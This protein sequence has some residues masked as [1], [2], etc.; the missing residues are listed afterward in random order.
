MVDPVLR[1]DAG[2]RLNESTIVVTGGAG[3][4]GS[5]VVA[6]LLAEGATVKVIDDLSTGRLENLRDSLGAGLADGDIRICDVRSTDA[7]D[8]IRLWRPE[9]VVHLAA[10]SNL[11]ASTRSPLVDADINIRGTVNVLDSCAEAETRLVVYA[12][13]SAIYGT[14]DGDAVPVAETAP[15]APT[16]PYG[17]SKATALKYLDWY[18]DHRSVDYTALVLGN[19]YG[20]RQVGPMCGVVGLMAQAAMTR[21]HLAIF[22]DGHQTRD[23]VFVA[24]VAEAVTAACTTGGL[25]LVN[26]A[27]GVE[28]TV[29]EIAGL[30][31]QAAG[32][33][34]LRHA[35]P[36]PG[37]V[38]RM[39][40]DISR[41]RDLL[42]WH[43]T[44]PLAEGVRI[45]VRAARRRDS[46]KE[47]S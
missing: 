10:Q 22:G 24:D 9:I 29:G 44:T 36:L 20:P 37:E 16:S 38:R 32:T 2:G 19:V 35:D 34:A 47:A 3:F 14:V 33:G 12:A 25:G 40:L 5:H 46:I 45:T 17:L 13:T 31:S 6:R 4:I 8:A 41:A 28:T 23:F 42:G 7:V 26:I 1:L 30:V 27:S 15:I 11:P 21:G 18:R 43:P 39:A